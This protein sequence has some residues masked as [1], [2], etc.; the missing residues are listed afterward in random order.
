MGKKSG[1]KQPAPSGAMPSW[2]QNAHKDLMARAS[3]ESMSPYTAYAGD[4]VAGE[5]QDSAY[6]RNARLRQISGTNAQINQGVQG[7]Q[8]L[9]S[10]TNASI[11]K[12][13]SAS[14]DAL[15]NAKAFNNYNQGKFAQFDSNAAKAYMSPYQQA[16]TDI[17]KR[18]A[19]VDYQKANIGRASDLVA[20]GAFGGSRQAIIQAEADKALAQQM[21]DM[22]IRGN[23][24]AF[25]N[26]QQQF[27]ADRQ[28]NFDAFRTN[29]DVDQARVDAM[30]R[31]GAQLYDAGQGV[32]GNRMEAATNLAKAGQQMYD[33]RASAIDD[34]YRMGR[35]VEQRE[36]A[37]L[38]ADYGD[39]L[40]ERDWSKNQMGWY[41][42][43]M[44][45]SAPSFTQ[46]AS[47]DSSDSV[48]ANLL[49]LGSMAVGA[50]SNNNNA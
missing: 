42:G 50:V 48:A 15:R 18:K 1:S 3:V 9:Q 14:A 38:D 33:N 37:Q 34:T 49:G 22:Q 35:D 41:G 29:S 36:Q 46:Y 5:T 28:A 44:T 10:G 21:S 30:L 31:S 17:G 12:S 7:L 43:I 8:G 40:T 6:A 45:G 24:D 19:L 11:N 32:Y 20:K 2:A 13:M 27:G 16:V 23:Q 25:L 47:N 26:A 4:R 39:Y